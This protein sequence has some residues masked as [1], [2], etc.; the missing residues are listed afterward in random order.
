MKFTSRD[1]DNDL[2]STDN[3][4]HG[5]GGWWYSD[6]GY[7]IELNDDYGDHYIHINGVKHLKLIAE[8]KIRPQNCK[9]S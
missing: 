2:D 4:S 8:M 5:N 9:I 1:R 3:C 7:C 6:C